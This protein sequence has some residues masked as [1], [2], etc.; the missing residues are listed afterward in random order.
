MRTTASIA[1]SLAVSLAATLV[2]AG[3]ASRSAPV[4]AA[5]TRLSEGAA[6]S[7]SPS[8]DGSR[9]AWL[10]D[11]APAPGAPKGQLACALRVAPVAGGA[12]RRI[13]EGV[14]AA[15]G[16]FAWA[17]D[18]SLAVIG[19]RDPATGAGELTLW[20]PDREPRV[21][22]PSATAFV[23]GPDSRIAIVSTGILLVASGEG[24][25]VPVRGGAGVGD[26]A[27]APA[28]GRSLA[29]VV[30]GASGAPILVAWRAAGEEPV[31]VARDVASFAFSPDGEMLA[32]IAGVAP[33][34]PGDLVASSLGTTGT[35]PPAV[36][37]ARAVGEFRWAPGARRLA[38]LT[39]FDPRVRAGTLASAAPGGAVVSFAPRVTS[40]EFSPGGE[41]LAYVRHVTDGGYAARLELSPSQAAEAGTVARDAAAFEFSPDGRWIYYR[42]GCAPGSDACAL[43]RAPGAGLAPGQSP[44]KLAE[45]VASFAI[46]RWRPDRV[47]VSIVRRD[48]AG[49]DLAL[50][51]GGRLVSLDGSVLAGSPRFLPPDGRKVAWIATRPDRA[52]VHVADAP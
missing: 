40:F 2:A 50:W 7:L 17:S 19:R 31:V 16:A 23:W 10:S 51:S 12:A 39:D 18:G 6:R 37:V 1:A 4:A 42:A 47:L 9:M 24:A 22:V 29:A 28:S 35:A 38:W 13:A 3:C 25:P 36:L 46:D 20:R 48:G 30:R 27:F 41:R 45:G 8:P 5:G 32:A 33:G 14:P 43:F 52:G 44:E 15:D 21:L 26:F 34:S 49:V 11:C